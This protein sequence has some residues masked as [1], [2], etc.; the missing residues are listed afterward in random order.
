MIPIDGGELSWELEFW[1]GSKERGKADIETGAEA[2]FAIR[3]NHRG[4][5]RMQA[6][7]KD[8]AGKTITSDATTLVIGENPAK[9]GRSF[10]Y[11]IIGGTRSAGDDYKRAI[12]LMDKLG[13]DIVRGDF[14]W[15]EIEPSRGEWR[16]AKYDRIVEDLK[17]RNIEMEAILCYTTQWASTGDR[18]AKNW[19]DWARAMPEMEPWLEYV[20]T[21]VKHFKDSV[22]YWEIWNEPDIGFWHDTPTNYVRLFNETASAIR[23]VDSNATILNGGLALIYSDHNPTFRETFLEKADK[24]NWNIRAYHDYNTFQQMMDRYPEHKALYRRSTVATLPIWINEGGFHTLV[25]DGDRQQTINLVKK[26]AYGPSLPQVEAYIWY[27][28][29]DIKPEGNDPENR[30]GVV[31]YYFRPKPAYGAY[32]YLIHELAS[33][34]YIAAKDGVTIVKGVWMQLYQG[35]ESHQLVIWQEGA[36]ALTPVMLKWLH[37]KNEVTTVTDLMGNPQ[38]FVQL[39][40]Q[41]LI[42][43]GNEP[44]Y[45]GLKGE[46][47]Y[48][49]SERFLN[50]PDTLALLPGTKPKVEIAVNNP[51]AET[52]QVELAS[53]LEGENENSTLTQVSVP[54]GGSRSVA[55]Q[56]PTLS[57][58]SASEGRM[59]VNVR[60]VGAD[61]SVEA[62]I[63]YERAVV[64]PRAQDNE[65]NYYHIELNKQTQIVNLFDT[66]GRSDQ[67]W[68][69]ADDLSAQGEVSYDENG[70]NLHIVA[71]DDHHFQAERAPTLWRGDSLQL[72]MRLATP[73]ATPL[74]ISLALNN[75]GE[76][77]GWV[78]AVPEEGNL[79][80]GGVDQKLLPYKVEKEKARVSY[81]LTIPWKIFG[82][83]TPPPEGFR[84]S[85]LVNDNDGDGRR[86]WIELSSGIGKQKDMSL[87]PLFICK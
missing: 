47:E 6:T 19:L 70:L 42:T 62:V 44:I 79:P 53:R 59:R 80:T 67:A 21:T 73:G 7:L 58:Q 46:A 1:D 68:R 4:W 55:L 78:N 81:T 39:K 23:E 13:V 20:K 25:P 38:S 63:P 51:T 17:Q 3:P 72:A 56:A 77:I 74:E 82:R 57:S 35:K 26:M 64:L 71:T 14:S 84:L 75:D 43:L 76:M 83:Q 65:K 54:A 2:K 86:Q 66:Q 61:G 87:F 69:G 12:E 37:Q 11:G 28:L 34:K 52:L 48:P 27:N 29:N 24:T 16:F 40:G 85:F 31:D 50:L 9:G 5:A 15:H 33:R 10:R 36:K 32:Q 30:F 18:N 49:S 60:P 22:H 45:I 8:H 41:V